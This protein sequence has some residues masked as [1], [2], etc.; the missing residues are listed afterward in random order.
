MASGEATKNSMFPATAL[1]YWLGTQGILDLRA[2][3]TCSE[4]S[5]FSLRAFH[6]ELLAGARFP[7]PLVA[8]TA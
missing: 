8:R 1:M 7:V 4:G 5:G 6:D 2:P 3:V